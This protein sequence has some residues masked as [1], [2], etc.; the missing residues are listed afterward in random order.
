MTYHKFDKVDLDY[1]HQK[2][3]SINVLGRVKQCIYY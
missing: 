3:M 2:L 1:Q